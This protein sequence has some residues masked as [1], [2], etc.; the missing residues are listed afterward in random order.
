MPRGARHKL[1]EEVEP[2]DAEDLLTTSEVARR[3]RLTRQTVQRMIKRGDLK[4][5]RIGRDWRVKRSTLEAF[6][7][8]TETS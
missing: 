2:L 1:A 4:A 3:L 8:E 5:S 6:L 7:R